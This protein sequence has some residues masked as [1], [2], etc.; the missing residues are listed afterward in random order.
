MKTISSRI[1]SLLLLVG[2]PVAIIVVTYYFSSGSKQEAARQLLND[3]AAKTQLTSS[4]VPWLQRAEPA[5]KRVLTANLEKIAADSLLILHPSGSN[6][7]LMYEVDR[8][9]DRIFVQLDLAWQGGALNS[10]YATV[11]IWEFDAEKHFAAKLLADTSGSQPDALVREQIDDY[12]RAVLYPV[13]QQSA[14]TWGR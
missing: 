10:E 8:R 11:L 4:L 5:T 6:P 3:A 14:S 1:N 2:V 9:N 7:K 12:F 13:V